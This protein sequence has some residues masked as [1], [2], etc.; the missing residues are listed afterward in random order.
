MADGS[1]SSCV[2]RIVVE[3]GEV[4][5]VSPVLCCRVD[6]LYRRGGVLVHI[7]ALVQVPLV[8]KVVHGELRAKFL[9][10]WRKKLLPISFVR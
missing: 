8:S 7:Y 2:G 4:S 6:S 5:Y 9:L 10:S 3:G 1:S